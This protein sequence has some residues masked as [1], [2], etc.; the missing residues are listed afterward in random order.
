MKE[1][2]VMFFCYAIVAGVAFFGV[3]VVIDWLIGAEYSGGQ[4]VLQ[5]ALFGVFFGAYEMYMEHRR[6]KNGKNSTK[7]AIEDKK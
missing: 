7:D 5:A 3:M 1:R 4:Y 2:I 6:E